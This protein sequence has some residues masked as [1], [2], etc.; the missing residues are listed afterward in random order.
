MLGNYAMTDFK[1]EHLFERNLEMQHSRTKS[2]RTTTDD[3]L[4]WSPCDLLY[5][6]ARILDIWDINFTIRECLCYGNLGIILNPK[7]IG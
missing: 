6:A 1:E 5:T 2:S 4:I 7:M 3:I